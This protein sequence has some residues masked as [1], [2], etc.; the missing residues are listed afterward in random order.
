MS[1]SRRR[2]LAGSAALAA[3]P[4]SRAQAAVRRAP[5]VPFLLDDASRLNETPISRQAILLA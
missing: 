1:V 5:S 3:V 2:F 4:P